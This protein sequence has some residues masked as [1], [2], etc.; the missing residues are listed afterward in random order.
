MKFFHL[1]V[2]VVVHEHWILG[3][4]VCLSVLFL[5]CEHAP[6]EELLVIVVKRSILVEVRRQ[7]LT[8]LIWNLTTRLFELLGLR[9]VFLTIHCNWTS[10]GVDGRSLLI[11]GD[12][13]VAH[14]QIVELIILKAL[15]VI[16]KIANLVLLGSWPSIN[17]LPLQTVFVLMLGL[18]PAHLKLF[19]LRRSPRILVYH[20]L[21]FACWFHFVV[22]IESTVLACLI[23]LT[24]NYHTVVVMSLCIVFRQLG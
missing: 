14:S 15:R 1:P 17:I 22:M 19:K 2:L 7:V 10:V 24:C 16:Y 8:A 23:L 18:L 4:L 21:V 13:D 3:Q 11:C 9:R 6:V 20:E 12:L 5:T